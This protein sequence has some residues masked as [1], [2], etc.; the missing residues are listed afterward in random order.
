MTKDEY[1]Q[2]LKEIAG[3]GDVVGA[4]AWRLRAECEAR[5]LEKFLPTTGGLLSQAMQCIS[6]IWI[7]FPSVVSD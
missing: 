7:Y 5:V 1:G 4:E 2:L 3:G 6:S